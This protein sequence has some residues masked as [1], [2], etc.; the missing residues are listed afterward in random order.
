MI[1]YLFDID[2]TLLRADGAGGRAFDRALVDVFALVDASRGIRFGGKTDYAILDE[3]LLARRGEVASD[4][5]R[6]RFIARYL[7]YLDD[8]LQNSQGFRVLPGAF[9]SLD[10]LATRNDV[11]IGVATGNVDAGAQAKLRRAGLHGRFALGGYGCD[12]HLRPRLVA[13]A[14]ERGRQHAGREPRSVVVIGDTIHDI[15]AARA[16]D[17]VA[18]AVTTG[19]DDAAALAHA[20]FLWT[21]LHELPAWH[22]TQFA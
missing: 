14:I 16:C 12:S 2:G 6:E 11:V 20:D 9:E 17:A 18:V 8:E 7:P 10:Y 21:S 15:S 4:H 3:I 19:A 5:E 1:L 13:R 22:A